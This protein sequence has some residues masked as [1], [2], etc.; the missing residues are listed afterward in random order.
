MWKLLGV[1][2][3]RVDFPTDFPV[4]W[5]SLVASL[6]PSLPVLRRAINH[7][8]WRYAMMEEYHSI[9]KNDVWNIFMRLEGKSLVG[10]LRSNMLWMAA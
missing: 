10:Y 5:F 2:S 7:Q 6:I 9:M 8:V 4:T 3:G 1:H